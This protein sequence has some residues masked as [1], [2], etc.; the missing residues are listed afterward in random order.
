MNWKKILHQ[1]ENGISF[2]SA[3]PSIGGVPS[4]LNLIAHGWYALPVRRAEM[5]WISNPQPNAKNIILTQVFIYR[6]RS[7]FDTARNE[8]YGACAPFHITFLMMQSFVF[9][10]FISHMKRTTWNDI[11]PGTTCYNLQQTSERYKVTYA[12]VE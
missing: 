9:I 6:N 12:S 10:C 7:E 4:I 2:L 8:S 11:S 1:K 5:D 3:G